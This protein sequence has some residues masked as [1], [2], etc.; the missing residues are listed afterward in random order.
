MLILSMPEQKNEDDDGDRHP[1]E[2]EKYRHVR[3][4]LNEAANAAT[5]SEVW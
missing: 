5:A 3:F 4:L 1:E 2:P